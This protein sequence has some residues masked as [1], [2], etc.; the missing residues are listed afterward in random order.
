MANTA[1]WSARHGAHLLALARGSLL[2]VS[3]GGLADVWRTDDLGGS[4]SQV[5]ADAGFPGRSAFASAVLADDSV[6]VMGGHSAG[7]YLGDVWRGTGEGV[8]WALVVASAPWGGRW[9]HTAA[10]VPG[11]GLVIV[12]G[13]QVAGT[14]TNDV[15]TSSNAG[16][17]WTQVTGSAAWSPREYC[18]LAAFSGGVLVLAGGYTSGGGHVNDVWRSSD[19]GATFQ[20]L[21][22]ATWSPRTRMQAVV[23]G[24]IIVI[25]GGEGADGSALHDVWG[26]ST[27]GGSW[28][29]LT[30]AAEWAGRTTFAMAALP[31]ASLIV[32]GG[33]PLSN[34]VW[35][36]PTVRR[37]AWFSSD[38]DRRRHGICGAFPGH[39][40]VTVTLP[41]AVPG[42]VT[43]P[44]AAAPY[45][46]STVYAPP[47]PTLSLPS[48]QPSVFANPTLL[49][50]VAFTSAVSGL[51][52]WD[53]RV[54]T[55][56]AVMQQ[57][58]SGST[59][60]WTLAVALD[61]ASVSTV[62]CPAGYTASVAG[63]W[64]TR[65]LGCV[66]SWMESNDACAPFTL[67]STTSDA[68]LTAVTAARTAAH[69]QY[70]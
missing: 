17:S 28:V 59:T 29:E 40:G 53:F 55:T 56:A 14:L 4:W 57:A 64:C 13:G 15:W 50:D 2:L 27:R 34:D 36:S 22:A 10:V 25:A 30:P 61:P 21:P 38:C 32:A 11:S 43:P 62:Q 42:T 6:L 16:A 24:S 48:F 23:V 46:V 37:H 33:Y 54:A 12:L 26:S 41:A 19:N 35:R 58:A 67:A 70:W 65:A 9:A 51:H 7:V 52:G 39:V 3:G 66:S 44:S 45:A 31:D 49:V 18:A 1:P 20:A 47:I 5:S 60:S 68:Q 8:F 69:E 63:T